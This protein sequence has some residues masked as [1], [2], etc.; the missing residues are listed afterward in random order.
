MVS[1]RSPSRDFEN[2]LR[3]VVGLNKD[4][5]W[6]TLKPYISN[7]VTFK[8]TPGIYTINDISEVVYTT[9]NHEGTLQIK[10][11]DITLK[12][13]LISKRLGGIFGTLKFNKKNFF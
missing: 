12:T 3:I 6:L 13:K 4:D 7:F 10:Y 8:I 5:V 9:G 1:A 11:D 2:Y